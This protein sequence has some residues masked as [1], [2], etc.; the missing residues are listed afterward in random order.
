MSGTRTSEKYLA[1]D[2]VK[3]CKACER[4]LPADID[5][6][7]LKKDTRDGLTSKCK[8][9]QGR[10]FTNHLT[11]IPKE[12]YKFCKK[13]DRE[14]PVDIKY[15]PPD[16]A[17]VD[18]FRSVCRECSEAH[19]KIHDVDWGQRWTEEE[20]N[21]LKENYCNYTNKELQ[22]LFFSNR[23]IRGI[24]TMADKLRCNGKSDDVWERINE[25][26]REV[27]KEVSTGRRLTERAKQ[28][29]SLKAKERY[30]KYG[31]PHKG[32]KR[33]PETCAKISELNRIR[34]SWK[35]KLN[36]RYKNPLCGKDNPNW[37]GG[38]TPLYQ[39]LRSDTRDWFV[40]SGELSNFKCVISGLK[41]DN[42]H[43][44]IPFKDIVKE[45]FDVLNL[46]FKDNI[47]DYTAAEESQIRNLLKELHIQYGLG[48]GLNKEVHKLFHDNYGYSNVTKEDFKSFLIGIQNGVYDEYFAE[49][50]LPIMLNLSAIDVLLN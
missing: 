4:E 5:H 10:Y 6:F 36:P 43:H 49:H 31:S 23:S 48:V 20:I 32:M 35:G 11:H 9:C 1:H 21:L 22:A 3:I 33:S 12:G 26:R 38:L 42:V 41:L 50:N 17:C 13:C 24:S 37:K 25:I 18:G 40:E 30:A 29:I 44:L 45:V 47:A 14:L 8:E 46:E 39:E 27:S 7:Y 19:F 15:F 28:L 2:G 34:G 16:K